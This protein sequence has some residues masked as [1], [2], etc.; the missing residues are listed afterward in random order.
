MATGVA[1]K[2]LATGTEWDLSGDALSGRQVYVYARGTTT[3]VT[4]YQDSGL[5]TPYM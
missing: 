4:V 1:L 3:Q 2:S 5:T